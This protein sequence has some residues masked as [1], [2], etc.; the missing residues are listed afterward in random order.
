[1]P[2]EIVALLRVVGLPAASKSGGN[3]GDAGDRVAVVPSQGTEL[4]YSTVV[5][6]QHY[7][8][9]GI[10]HVL[11]QVAV[12]ILELPVISHQDG[13]YLVRVSVFPLILATQAVWSPWAQSAASN[14]ALWQSS[15][16]RNYPA[17]WLCVW[18]SINRRHRCGYQVASARAGV[19]VVTPQGTGVSQPRRIPLGSLSVATCL[20]LV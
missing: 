16:P 17:C 5:V 3:F 14:N 8:R 19:Y 6:E 11:Q 20:A 15:K 4:K 1:M 18:S 13:G 7:D 12:G 9:E 2:A 10:G